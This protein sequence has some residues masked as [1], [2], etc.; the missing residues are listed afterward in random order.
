MPVMRTTSRVTHEELPET[1]RLGR[2]LPIIRPLNYERQFWR[3]PVFLTATR[4]VDIF[5]L[6]T[7][8]SEN[9][10]YLYRV[11]DIPPTTASLMRPSGHRT[12]AIA[13]LHIALTVC[14]PQT[15]AECRV[16]LVAHMRWAAEFF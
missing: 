7:R 15:Y 11:S 10:F 8:L 12:L 5:N 2:F 1:R 3:S 6:F 9:C 13:L 14:S 16:V 4:D